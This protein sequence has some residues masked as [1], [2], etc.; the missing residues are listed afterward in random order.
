MNTISNSH[1]RKIQ[2]KIFFKNLLSWMNKGDFV[3][4]YCMNWCH[5]VKKII[6]VIAWSSIHSK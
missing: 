1:C 4:L 5:W 3:S 6:T 2:K